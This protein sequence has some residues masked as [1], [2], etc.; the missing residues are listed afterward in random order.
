MQPQLLPM[1][2]LD[3]LPRP[4]LQAP[5]QPS[6]H[7]VSRRRSTSR[8]GPRWTREELQL[9]E[10]RVALEAIGDNSAST[11]PLRVLQCLSQEKRAENASQSLRKEK[12]ELSDA[13]SLLRSTST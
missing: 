11:R 6:L 13:L 12:L 5:P 10:R 1:L 9:S 7:G 2:S 4:F 8:L 3:P